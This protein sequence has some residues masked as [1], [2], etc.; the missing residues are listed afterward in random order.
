YTGSERSA[1]VGNLTRIYGPDATVELGT[2]GLLNAQ[3]LRRLDDD[4][5]FGSCSASAPCPGGVTTPYSTTVDAAFAEALFWPDGPAGRYILSGSYNWVYADR[6]VIALGLGEQDTPPGYLRRYSAASGG[7]HYLLRRNV[8][9]MGE[10]GWDF[11]R[12]Q[13]RL[14][15][16]TVLAF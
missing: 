14:I 5:F 10:L 4:P 12:D 1:G 9:L 7:L 13:G 6:P 15:L 16:G 8:R 3:F 2:K 11:E